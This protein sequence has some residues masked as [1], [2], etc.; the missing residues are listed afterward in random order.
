MKLKL[1]VEEYAVCRLNNDSKI[2]TW[3]EYG[4]RAAP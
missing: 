1:L 3:I 2:P 4:S